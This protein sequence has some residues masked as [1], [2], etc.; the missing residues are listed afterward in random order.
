M[1]E[2]GLDRG[3]DERPGSLQRGEGG[4][5][6]ALPAALTA[7][8]AHHRAV[9]ERLCDVY[10]EEYQRALAESDGD[11]DYAAFAENYRFQIPA[12]AHWR[13]VRAV[14]IHVGQAIQNATRAIEQT[15]Q[16][17]L[18][19]SSVT[20]SGPTRSDSR[21]RRSATWWSTSPR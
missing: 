12:G 8:R 13:D 10:D 1:V 17:Q 14:T 15:N 16:G 11:V 6:D 2:A 3:P 18:T 21:T 19:A 4:G 5:D 20:R 7:E 9:V